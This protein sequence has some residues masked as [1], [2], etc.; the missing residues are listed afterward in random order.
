[1]PRPD[2][3][4]VDSSYLDDICAELSG[5]TEEMARSDENRKRIDEEL[6]SNASE[7]LGLSRERRRRDIRREEIESRRRP[8]RDIEEGFDA[9]EGSSSPDLVNI[10]DE[11]DGEIEIEEEKDESPRMESRRR[12]SPNRRVNPDDFDEPRRRPKYSEEDDSIS[13]DRPQRSRRRPMMEED[14]EEFVPRKRRKVNSGSILEK[15]HLQPKY[16]AIIVAVIAFFGIGAFLD[17]KTGGKGS[18]VSQEVVPSSQ[19]N[20]ESTDSGSS[21]FEQSGNESEETD[22][23]EYIESSGSS[24]SSTVERGE[25]YNDTKVSFSK[26]VYDDSISVS[27]FLEF[28]G[29]SC[30]PKFVGY[31]DVLEREIEFQVTPDEYNSYLNGVRIDVTYRALEKDGITYV[32]DIKIK[33]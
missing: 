20:V 10:P 7:E 19:E 25:L 4:S 15:I 1:M 30:I 23:E 17:N 18:E 16:V 11:F 28:R 13:I 33:K 12:E 29:A 21:A 31:S 32:T 22:N 6:E 9:F 26:E 5:I 27:K 2:R 8:S 14:E 24:G 3:N